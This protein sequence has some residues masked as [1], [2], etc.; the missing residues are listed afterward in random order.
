MALQVWLPLNKENNLTSVGLLNY[1]FLKADNPIFSTQ[2]KIGGCYY[3]DGVNDNLYYSDN[4]KLS[5]GGKEI[6]YACWFKCSKNNASGVLIDL[7]ADLVLT[8]RY[9][10]SGIKFGY[11]RAYRNS[12][13]NRTGDAPV[14]ST[15]YNADVW[16]HIAITFD[17]QFNKLYVDGQLSQAWNS[18]S[19]YTT[20]WEPLLTATSYKNIAIG[21]SYGSA[22]FADGSINDVRIYDHCLS[23]KEVKEISKAL[24]L[25]YQF[26]DSYVEGTTNLITT[27]DCLSST[28][29]NGASGKYGYGTTTDM[30][31]TTGVFNDRFCTKVYMGTSGLDAYP[32]VYINNS[33]VSNGTNSPEYK[34]LS[35][36]F[37]TNNSTT[38][39]IIPYKLGS[40]SATCD[41]TN[42][43]NMKSGSGINT[44]T[45][46]VIPNMWNHIIMILHGTTDADAQ[47]GYIRMGS[48]KHTSNTNYYWLF[49]N[50]QLETKDH[51]TGYAGIGGTRTSTTVYD[52]SG[53]DNNGTINANLQI[54]N[55]SSR[56]DKS[57]LFD[58]IN[59]SITVPYNA[60]NP[61]AIFTLNLWFK[62][63]ALGSKNYETLFGGP[64][65][66]EMD[67]RANNASTLSLYMASV[68]GGNVFSPF[69]FGEWY[70]ITMTRDGVNEK[71]YVN[72]VLKKT[73]EA[74]AMPTGTYYIGAWKTAAQ[75]NYYGEISDFRI[76]ATILSDD[77]IT[78]LYNTS[79]FI[80]NNGSVASYEFNENA[81]VP[82]SF[83][84]GIFSTEEYFECM[85][86]NIKVLDDGSTWLRILHHNAPSTNLFTSSNCWNYESENLYSNLSILQNLTQTEY[87]FLVY[88]KLESSSTESEIRWKQTN[89][90]STTTS[91]TGFTLISGTAAHL[92]PGL[93]KSGTQ[94]GAIDISGNDWWCCCG[95]Y[96]AYQGGIPGFNGVVK[97][98]YMDL[99]IRIYNTN[100]I[101]VTNAAFYKNCIRT[102]QLIE[103]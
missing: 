42:T 41:W 38:T 17:H 29:Y 102:N 97:T 33:F 48:V 10:S 57:T 62:K 30:Y 67:T 13:N 91:A 71:Y 66:F 7:F 99:Y 84:N 20:N 76:Y 54:V 21:R 53:Y 92:S 72:G 79:A 39:V 40:G 23:P 98:G 77:D 26:N 100:L 32:Y 78:E 65:G 14:G 8:Y 37:Y 19:L 52:L 60:I 47:W 24:V 69:N 88:E 70:M 50:M 55:E 16:H 89:N 1:S 34:T 83:K 31:K 5:W 103:I 80:C 56:Y 15:Y 96:T 46:S 94:H 51:A 27:T 101:N 86:N 87:E 49:A 43:T 35:F 95:C 90:P 58:G 75:Q 82:Q 2:G 85:P 22:T 12:S 81:S 4:N 25:H 45:I 93:V 18:S 11:W 63:N 6:S 28:C 9:D 44:A 36:D 73:I 61:S 64:S 74:K 3:F 68:R 59:S